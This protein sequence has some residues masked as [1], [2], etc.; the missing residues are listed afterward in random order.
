MGSLKEMLSRQKPV[1]WV[2][3]PT[4]PENSAQPTRVIA[5]LTDV[6]VDADACKLSFKDGR[7]FQDQ[8]WESMQTWQL[9]VS[10]I[11][12]VRVESLVGFVERLR[13]EGRQPGWATQ[14]KPTVFVLEFLAAPNH[15][16]DVH[17]W[18][19]NSANEV[20]ERDLQQ[21]LAFI[22]FADETSAN[23]AAKTLE[24]AQSLCA[25]RR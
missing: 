17:R 14:T 12:H 2:Q 22:V 25:T 13:A 21:S 4:N 19:K 24:H 11:D 5:T 6:T 8:R 9:N 3:T 16:F 23:E 18:S 7:V 15:K 10:D 1:Q 20:S